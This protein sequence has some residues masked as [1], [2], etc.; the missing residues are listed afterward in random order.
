MQKLFRVIC[1]YGKLRLINLILKKFM[2]TKKVLVVGGAGYIGS[3][4]NK[5]LRKAGYDT[6][7]FDDL[8]RGNLQTLQNTPLIQGNLSDFDLLFKIF[9]TYSISTVMHFAAFTDVGESTRRP[10][11]Y[12]TNN[13]VCTL[14]LLNAM[15]K[16]EVPYL[17]FSSS[18][19]IF[20]HPHTPTIDETHPYTPINPYGQSKL[21]I[22]KI[23]LDYD[24]A[25]GLKSCCLRYFN[26]AGGDPS[27]EIKYYQNQ[28]TNLIP[29]TLKNLKTEKNTITIYGTD[30]E[31][32]DGTCI[33]DYIH[34]ED[35]GVAHLLGMQKLK[36]SHLS[37]QYNLGIGRGYSV[38]EVLNAVKQIT[39][40]PLTL[41]ESERRKGDPAV[42]IANASKACSELNWKPHYQDIHTMIEHAWKALDYI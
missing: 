10:D 25:Y 14:N 20:G 42:L 31:T 18:A 36:S 28:I 21:M 7:V 9:E 17:I 13:V 16:Y 39:V 1:G 22:E 24:H 37:C 26:A 6:L 38:K 30:Y 3:H 4:V 32:P 15:V 34:I 35:L 40:K 19:A 5:M 2:K 8:S 27:G 12:Y 11:K 29:L 23:L 41:I 33:R